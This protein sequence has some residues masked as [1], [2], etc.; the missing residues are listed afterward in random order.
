MSGQL[1]FVVTT[2]GFELDY[3]LRTIAPHHRGT[4]NPLNHLQH[5][6]KPHNGARSL[7]TNRDNKDELAPMDGSVKNTDAKTK[8]QIQNNNLAMLGQEIHWVATQM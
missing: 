7:A 8:S 6:G 3:F 1:N 4:S 2:V 5:I